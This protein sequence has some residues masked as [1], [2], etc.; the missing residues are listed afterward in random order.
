M[1]SPPLGRERARHGAAWFLLWSALGLLAVFRL[2]PLSE[3]LGY[4]R[5]VPA[6]LLLAGLAVTGLDGLLGAARIQLFSGAL[7]PGLRFRTSLAACVANI[8]L[9][10][11]TPSQSGGGPAQIYVLCKDGMPFAAA[12]LSSVM[13]FLNSIVFLLGCAAFV[14]FFHPGRALPGGLVLLSRG[15]LALF[16]A[17]VAAFLLAVLAPRTFERLFRGLLRAVPPLERALSRRGWT[18]SFARSVHEYHGIM[19]FYLTRARGALLGGALLTALIYVNKFAAAWVV[20]RGL[21]GTASFADVLVIQMV[22][23]LV[24]YFAPS[25]GA[26]GVAELTAGLL[27]GPLLPRGSAGVFTALWRTFTLY[28][29]MVAGGIVFFRY[30]LREDRGGR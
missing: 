4:A 17:V 16:T 10:G 28:L 11:V 13:C 7:H 23:L 19:G 15:T 26:S 9:G 24:F 14:T 27:M 20:L 3:S 1:T 6:W 29:G 12:T 21:G 2:A 5:R 22:Q 30:L 25:P 18:E 8:F